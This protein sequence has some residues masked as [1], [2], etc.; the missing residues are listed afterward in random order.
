MV[1]NEIHIYQ[2]YLLSQLF[3]KYR[4]LCF[5]VFYSFSSSSTHRYPTLPP[6]HLLS[7]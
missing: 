1:L 6:H 5:T 3:N 7:T 2:L 4:Y